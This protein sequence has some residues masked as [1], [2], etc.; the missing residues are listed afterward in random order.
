M[1]IL[2][3]RAAR[4]WSVA[5]VAERFLLTEMTIEN[6][7]RRLDDGGEAALVRLEQPVNRYPDYVAYLVRHLKALSPAL[8][9]ARIAQMLA[10][11][12]LHLSASTVRRM[13][14]RHLRDDDTGV[15]PV[16]V[17]ERRLSGGRPVKGRD[18]S[19]S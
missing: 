2:R 13:L 10:R 11:A 15:L 9:K 8:G 1:Q 18:L 14:Q 12:G 7:M 17:P 5:Q 16:V 3:L 4:G 19:R 6:W